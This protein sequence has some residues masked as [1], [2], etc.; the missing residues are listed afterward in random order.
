MTKE[1]N[2]TTP[3]PKINFKV[4]YLSIFLISFIL[5][6]TSLK[7]QYSMDDN[8]VTSTYDSQHP[9]VEGGLKSIPKIFSSHFVTNSKQS[10]AYRPV[11]TTTFALEYQLFGQNPMVSHLVNVLLYALTVIV[12]FRVL[13]LLWGEEKY[14]LSV[15]TCLIFIIHPLHSEVINNIKC[16]DELLS[17]FFGLFVIQNTIKYLDKKKLKYIIFAFVFLVLSILSKRNGIIFL[18]VT[19]LAIF[20]FRNFKFE[21]KKT[22][23]LVSS[24]IGAFVVFKL[25]NKLLLTDSVSRTMY[26]FE[27][28]LFH[29]SFSARI[30]MFFYSNF[31]YLALLILPY[32]L[33]Y[34][35][36]YD[37]VII[38]DWSNPIVYFALAVML[39][40]LV[41]I[42]YRWKK[43]EI[44][45]FGILFYLFAI[46]GAC[47]LLFPAVGII[48]ERFAYVATIG[49]SISLGYV[50]YCLFYASNA[51]FKSQKSLAF[52]SILAISITSLIYV[53]GRNK[54]WYD[55]QTLYESDFPHLQ[56]SFKAHSLLAQ[57][58]Y[59]KALTLR[60]TAGNQAE[61]NSLVNQSENIFMNSLGIYSEYA[62]LYNNLGALHYTFKADLDSA[63]YFFSKALEL[64][65][66]YPEAL[67]NKGNINLQ[68]FKYLTLIQ[69]SL[70]SIGS[71]DS[72]LS[73]G[74]QKIS[75]S[76]LIQLEKLGLS[77]EI[78]QRQIPSLIL[79]AASNINTNEE[80][81]LRLE[82][83]INTL[84]TN[85][86]LKQYFAIEELHN[87]L[88]SNGQQIVQSYQNGELPNHLFD[89]ITQTILASYLN[90]N[91]A[92]I[93]FKNLSKEIDLRIEHCSENISIY[94]T[95]CLDNFPDY[96]P[97]YKGLN[98]YFTYQN[99]YQAVIDINSRALKVESF[100][101][102]HEFYE[103]IALAYLAL[104]EFEQAKSN[105]E[106]ALKE[107]NENFDAVSNSARPMDNKAQ[108]M[109]GLNMKRKNVISYLFNICKQLNL[110]EE[111]AKYEQLLN[112]AL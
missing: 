80:F 50:F 67:F 82:N 92:N 79:N 60:G 68:K 85:N 26:Y 87:I 94:M 97:P 106:M 53:N 89:Y 61:I 42:V 29:D 6:G 51:R 86:Q 69:K 75:G 40:T 33:R 34:Y 5:Y 66:M 70:T 39:A 21:L 96:Y 52:L 8:L 81:L 55:A 74:N 38:A 77:F 4:Y 90:E 103:K 76:D 109:N 17:L 88:A 2:T 19:P 46:G 44:W 108:L 48:A 105:F 15:L 73:Q 7:N 13:N 58:Y 27:N 107:L 9:S 112:T 78:I 1:K 45:A 99:D 101:Y 91:L 25:M 10:Y 54:A 64:D 41:I 11:T 56:K 23:I 31:Y 71:N 57:N 12:L 63:E 59:T 37:Q 28:P 72:I 111:G 30:P 3:K 102:Y 22:A 24:L 43:K 84:I 100:D 49:F 35:Y 104:N 20:Y 83:S 47:N 14:V 36:G 65:S 110:T 32:P 93:S 95:M 16:R 98:E 18:F 62:V